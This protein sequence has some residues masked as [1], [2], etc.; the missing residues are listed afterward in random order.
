LTEIHR[1]RLNPIRSSDAKRLE[2][3]RSGGRRRVVYVSFDWRERHSEDETSTN[4]FW[5]RNR[6][7]TAVRGGLGSEIDVQEPI[8]SSPEAQH[9]SKWIALRL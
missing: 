1:E 9:D 6:K 5:D 4:R 7:T 8:A 3:E 2:L